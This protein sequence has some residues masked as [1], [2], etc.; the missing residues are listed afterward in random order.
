MPG[1]ISQYPT[2][3]IRCQYASIPYQ[4]RPIHYFTGF[5]WNR[6]ELTKMTS[7]IIVLAAFFIMYLIVFLGQIKRKKENQFSS[8]EE[9]HRT[10]D[11]YKSTSQTRETIYK[12]STDRN[13]STNSPSKS[14]YTY[15]YITKYNTPK[16][17]QRDYQEKR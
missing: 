8:V 9:F 7:I 17:H 11:R 4:R 15:K 14:K 5:E 3:R 13:N 12:R 16:N 6:K 2:G 10:Y 1:T